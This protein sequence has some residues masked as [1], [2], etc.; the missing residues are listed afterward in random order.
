MTLKINSGDILGMG[1]FGF[2][3]KGELTNEVQII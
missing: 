2:V 3:C 1:G